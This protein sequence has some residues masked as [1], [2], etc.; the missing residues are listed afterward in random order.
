MNNSRLILIN[1]VVLL[2]LIGGGFAAYYYYNQ[3]Y[4]YITT[5]NARI[6][7]Q[8]ITINALGTGKISDWNANVGSKLS[9]GQSLG[10]IQLVGTGTTTTTSPS[11]TP[12]TTMT[13]NI[14]T[15]ANGTIVQQNV[16]PNS[17]VATGTTLARAYDMDNLWVS[18]NI[19]ETDMSNIKQNETVDVSIDTYPGTTLTGKITQIGLTTAAQFSLLPQQNTNANFTKVIQ[20]V[21]IVITLD[22]YKGLNLIPGMSVTAQIH[23]RE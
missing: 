1:A 16:I 4:H 9:A 19:N 3:S 8:L 22:G 12:S 5:D 23:I 11:T 13:M 15:P 17:F 7:G 6:D 14:T 10:T 20:V 18:A 2:L 21:P